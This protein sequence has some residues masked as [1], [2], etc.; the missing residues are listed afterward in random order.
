MNQGQYNKGVL[1]WPFHKEDHSAA[2]ASPKDARCSAVGKIMICQHIL[3]VVSFQVK[4]L[5]KENQSHKPLVRVLH[6]AQK[7]KEVMISLHGNKVHSVHF[8]IL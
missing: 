4:V 6:S 3:F 8:K 2:T 7:L 1:K 5:H